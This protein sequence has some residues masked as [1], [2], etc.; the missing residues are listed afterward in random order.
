MVFSSMVVL[1]RTVQPK[2]SR[3]KAW[4]SIVSRGPSVSR[5]R[6]LCKIR[7]PRSSCPFEHLD[8]VLREGRELACRCEEGLDLEGVPA[9]AGGIR[10]AH[11]VHGLDGGENRSHD[12]APANRQRAAPAR[13]DDV[14]A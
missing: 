10:E 12:L 13:L 1:D 14:A 6:P 9:P 4:G 8:H 7:A 11:D 5:G 2:S 3:L